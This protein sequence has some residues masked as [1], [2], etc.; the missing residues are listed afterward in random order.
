MAK[1]QEETRIKDQ[2]GRVNVPPQIAQMLGIPEGAIDKELLQKIESN[3]P[4]PAE[5]G[6][7]NMP[8]SAAELVAKVFSEGQANKRTAQ[9]AGATVQAANIRADATKAARAVP[10]QDDEILS[11]LAQQVASGQLKP[12][13]IP[14]KPEYKRAVLAKIGMSGTAIPDPK[15][16][17]KMDQFSTAQSMM[18]SLTESINNFKNAKGIVESTKALAQVSAE[19]EAFSRLVGRSLGEKG[20]FTDQDKEDFARVLT[21]STPVLA[22]APSWSEERAKRL[23]KVMETVR[24]RT[25]DDFEK[26]SG[27]KY[28]EGGRLTG[29]GNEGTPTPSP[30]AAPAESG[31]KIGDVKTFKNGNKGKWDGKGWV[32]VQ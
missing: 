5:M 27:A 3:V 28:R 23:G 10:E 26:R 16:L 24:K 17:E 20:V 29:A 25:L 22:W 4:I 1:L 21:T 12:S 15:F 32:Q 8:K 13:Q 14:G 18:G 31:P 30:S 11:S 19:R 9:S 7:G 2:G 6:G